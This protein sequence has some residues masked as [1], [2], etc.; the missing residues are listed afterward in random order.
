MSKRFFLG[1]CG[2][3]LCACSSGGEKSDSGSA[4]SAGGLSSAGNSAPSTSTPCPDNY[5]TFS[6]G[7]SGT[8]VTD[9]ASNISMRVEDGPIPP[10]FGNNTWTVSMTDATGAP[11]TNAHIT[12]ACAFMSVH[13]HGSNPKQMTNLGGGKYTLK[14]QNTRM[15][16]PWEVQFWIDPTG[17]TPDYVP[18]TILADGKQC[19]PT[20]GPAGKP[21]FEFNIC[22]PD[23]TD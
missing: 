9:P 4:S 12:W 5:K 13:G 6:V 17:A 1:A 19:N 7:P 21:N 23:S 2:V 16:G 3:L 15:F 8:V 14:D 11:A 20:T 10:I 18:T 22:V